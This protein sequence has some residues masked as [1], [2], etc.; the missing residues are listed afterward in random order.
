MKTYKRAFVTMLMG[1]VG[2]PFAGAVAAIIGGFFIDNTILLVIIG[3]VICAVILLITIFGENISFT[4]SENGQLSY[5]KRG[6][7]RGQYDI[8]RC[9][10]GYYRKSRGAT[11]HNISLRI[12]PVGEDEKDTVYIDASPLGQNRFE[13]M[14]ADLERS[15]ANTP[16]VLSAQNK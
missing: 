7:L 13:R 10:V 5:Y 4:L 1:I 6:D 3:A 8:P 14:Y 11:D 9:H 16:E 12:L 2:A 15:S